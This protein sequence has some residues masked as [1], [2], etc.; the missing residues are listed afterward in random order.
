MRLSEPRRVARPRRKVASRLDLAPGRETPT[1]LPLPSQPDRRAVGVPGRHVVGSRPERGTAPPVQRAPMGT[2]TPTSASAEVTDVPPPS[3]ATPRTPPLSRA[4]A[5]LAFGQDTPWS[6]SRRS[7]D[8]L[9]QSASPCRRQGPRGSHCTFAPARRPPT[10]GADSSDVL[11]NP[12]GRSSSVQLPTKR[13]GRLRE[14]GSDTR[15]R[16]GYPARTLRPRRTR[17]FPASV[18]R[19]GRARR[20]RS[21]SLR[22]SRARSLRRF[23]RR[24]P[25]RPTT[26][27]PAV[28][29]SST[30]SRVSYTTTIRIGLRSSS[31]GAI[32]PRNRIVP[33]SGSRA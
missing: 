17:W 31:K 23:R 32:G 9:C 25:G 18:A 27:T 7:P 19:G 30:P 8:R 13:L 4:P 20:G 21:R 12:A 22:A 28:I 29:R 26:P 24:G 16:T 1:L 15:C 6:A 11:A 2:L 14:P 3:N 10:S 5:D 33:E